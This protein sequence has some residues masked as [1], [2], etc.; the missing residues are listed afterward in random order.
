MS[1]VLLLAAILCTGCESKGS[2]GGA[3]GGG[4]TN[5]GVGDKID[6]AGDRAAD[7]MKDMVP[8]KVKSAANAVDKSLDKL[9]ADE[10][11]EHVKNAQDMI[12][13]GEEPREDCGWAARAQDS[14]GKKM[15]LQLCAYEVPMIRARR[16]LVAAE[17]AR[18]EQR[19]APSLT[20]CSSDEWANV[21]AKLDTDHGGKAEWTD[22]KA[23][24][25]KACPGS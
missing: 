10:V 3:G 13:R 6:K 17:K 8:D 19:D 2:S 9:D 15:L 7:K 22:F 21:K 18:A 20:E 1:R 16:A 24:W 5:D 25:A 14:E 23:R 12:A 4:T 11:A